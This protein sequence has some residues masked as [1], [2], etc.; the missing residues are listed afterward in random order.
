[1]TF[2]RKAAGFEHRGVSAT[3][4]NNSRAEASASDDIKRAATALLPPKIALRLLAARHYFAGEPELRQIA[5]LVN[6]Q[7]ESIDAGAHH[8]VYAYFLARHS[9]WV[10]CYEPYPKDANFLAEAFKGRNVK[11]YPYALSDC[12]GEAELHIPAGAGEETGGQ[13]SLMTPLGRVTPEKRLM[14]E[15]RRLDQMGHKNV[16]FIKVDVEGHERPVVAG[17]A[18]LLEEERPLLLVELHGYE[19]E[20]PHRLLHEIKAP[21]YTGW[22]LNSGRWQELD[23]FRAVVHAR[24]EDAGARGRCYRKNFLFVPVEQLDVLRGQPSVGRFQ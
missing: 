1:M 4:S 17:A 6:P 3:R 20:D 15:T 9:Y 8:G 18:K 11:V 21:E 19:G 10:H 16:G 7:K 13:P 2:G 5:R 23:D 22:F 24:M 14:V 12:E